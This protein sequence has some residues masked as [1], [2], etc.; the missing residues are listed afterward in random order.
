MQGRVCSNPAR[1]AERTSRGRQRGSCPPLSSPGQRDPADLLRLPGKEQVPQAHGR[2]CKYRQ[3]GATAAPPCLP[4]EPG[5]ISA[6]SSPDG[7]GVGVSRWPECHGN[8]ALGCVRVCPS[9]W[10]SQQPFQMCFQLPG[11]RGGLE[12][13][14][15]PTRVTV[16]SSARDH[17]GPRALYLA[18]PG[19]AGGPG[20]AARPQRLRQAGQA[21][22]VMC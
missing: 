22:I 9:M 20:P 7:E 1:A 18:P 17:R 21:C 11:S 5:L 19:T 13:S 3:P 4:P 10:P 8:A 6:P 16:L 14:S 15:Q 2:L 12:V